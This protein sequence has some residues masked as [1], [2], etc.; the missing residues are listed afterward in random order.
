M[1]D[2]EQGDGRPDDHESACACD[3]PECEGG[4]QA[5]D[6]ARGDAHRGGDGLEDLNAGPRRWVHKFS[7]RTQSHGPE[8]ACSLTAR[9]L[10]RGERVRELAGS[11]ARVRVR[12]RVRMAS[13]RDG[14]GRVYSL[15]HG[16]RYVSRGAV[17]VTGNA[18]GRGSQPSEATRLVLTRPHSASNRP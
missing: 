9:G 17:R 14:E 18:S 1:T 2:L 5:G 16:S 15:D 4:S 13:V 3:S 7:A 8:C 6:E 12:V 10:P 11:R